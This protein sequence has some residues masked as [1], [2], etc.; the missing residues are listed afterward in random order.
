MPD[1]LI[2]DLPVDLHRRLK[3]EAKAHHR[4][5]NQQI[6]QI[7]EAHLE[8]PGIPDFKPF[9]LGEPLT[10]AFIQKARKEGR[11]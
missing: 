8:R 10:A 5:M 6:R 2:K 11:K 9:V 7:L 3:D 4:S 1:I